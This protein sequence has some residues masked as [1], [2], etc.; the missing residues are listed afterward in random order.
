MCGILDTVYTTSI[1]MSYKIAATVHESQHCSGVKFKVFPKTYGRRMELEQSL[2]RYREE[3]MGFVQQKDAIWNTARE[4]ALKNLGLALPSASSQV[5]LTITAEPEGKAKADV[6][7]DPA[8]LQAEIMR[9]LNAGKLLE[10]EDKADRVQLEKLRPVYLKIYLSEVSELD[11]DGV[12][13]KFSSK[14]SESD[15][16]RF[17]TDAPAELIDE[18]FEVIAERLHMSEQ[19]KAVFGLST[20]SGGRAVATTISTTAANAESAS[21][22]SSETASSQ[23][24]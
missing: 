19:D 12:P 7:P 17:Y 16:N 3:I 20:T 21:S 14:M 6:P 13:L 2:A 23:T 11:I 10:I 22:T 4:Q 24:S 5:A 1:T 15:Q 9:N 18:I 8:M